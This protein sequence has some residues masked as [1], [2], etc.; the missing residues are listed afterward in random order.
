MNIKEQIIQEMEQV[1]EH[2]LEE[3]LAF[4]RSLKVKH[5]P[6]GKAFNAYL[7]T[8]E[9]WSMV[10]LRLADSWICAQIRCACYPPKP[11]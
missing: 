10:Y 11:D 1:P 8:E 3:V 5:P 6:E 9:K 4:V 7:E 2:R